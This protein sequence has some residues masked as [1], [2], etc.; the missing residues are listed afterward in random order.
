MLPSHAI[1]NASASYREHQ[2]VVSI[3]AKDGYEGMFYVEISFRNPQSYAWCREL[4][5]YATWNEID[6]PDGPGSGW[7]ESEDWT[8]TYEVPECVKTKT[9]EPVAR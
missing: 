4:D 3:R 5:T 9:L 7:T 6:P 1:V 8:G 2:T